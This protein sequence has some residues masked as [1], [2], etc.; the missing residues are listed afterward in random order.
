[1][2]YDKPAPSRINTSWTLIFAVAA[3]AA[4]TVTAGVAL[5]TGIKSAMKRDQE[6]T[7]IAIAFA[8]NSMLYF[9]DCPRLVQQMLEE[10]VT[11][12]QDSCLRGGA[13]LSSLWKNG[14]GMVQKFATKAA[15]ID[16]ENVDSK[17]SQNYDIGSKTVDEMLSSRKGWDFLVLNDHTQ[18]PA[19]QD[20]ME[21]T[22]KALR[23]RYA[24]SILRN[25]VM[26][27]ILVQT[28]A[29]RVAGLKE[30]EDLGSFDEMTN[31]VAEGLRSYKETLEGE[32]IADC[33]IAPVGE[34]Y[35]YLH[36]N[37]KDLWEKLYSHDDFHPSPHGT[38]LEA[39]VI[40]CTCFPDSQE[41]VPP[42]YNST[43]WESSRIMQP[44]DE[45]PL[46]RPTEEEAME[47]RAVAC[48]ICGVSPP[49]DE[50]MMLSD[51][52]PDAL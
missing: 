5:E 23:E 12:H 35:R 24:P 16:E 51:L 17:N 46:P 6:Q 52:K 32:G 41:L 27:T 37:N 11:V 20:T 29:Y 25:N 36:D 43:W 21:Q 18:S 8:G 31:L 50:Q 26:T 38:W 3:T 9:N 13:T 30:S 49:K 42:I 39:C 28:P 19:R 40:F 33:R 4:L 47:L 15:L 7:E 22:E 14:N 2:E 45:A 34:A 48:A 44:S 1:M 10:K